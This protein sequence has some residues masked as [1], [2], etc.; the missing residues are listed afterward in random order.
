[1]HWVV[2]VLQTALIEVTP[3]RPMCLEEYAEFKPLGRLALREGG[4][5]LAVGII[6]Q[7]LEER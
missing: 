6:T 1:M 3:S 4:H 7:I 2:V 5:T